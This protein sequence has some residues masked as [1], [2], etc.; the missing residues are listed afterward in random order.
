[1]KINE[2]HNSILEELFTVKPFGLWTD[3]MKKD[4]D[5]LK[6]LIREKQAMI[7]AAPEGR[8]EISGGKAS[9][10]Y[11]C[12]SEG[13]RIYLGKDQEAT[14]EALAQKGYDEKVLK[15][16]EALLHS[17]EKIE[18]L[19][20]TPQLPDRF[21]S[22][23]SGRKELILPDYLPEELFRE[24]WDSLDYE[25]K[26]FDPNYPE[27]YTSQMERVRSK[28]EG[29]IGTRLNQ[30]GILYHYE[31]PL[32][33]PSY[34]IVFPDFTVVNMRTRQIYLWEHLGMMDNEGYARDAMRKIETYRA[35]GYYPGINLILTHETQKRPLNLKDIDL[36]IDLYLQ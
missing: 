22:M 6:K 1:M 32:L 34:G 10:F 17:L 29:T 12:D 21:S 31:Y 4:M 26:P 27:F 2:V 23:K 36:M 8:L 13:R 30:R 28:T 35:N 20:N 5:R 19:V 14:A 24:L 25:G 33:L 15:D 9:R 7:N 11:Q 16:A 3:G 18:T